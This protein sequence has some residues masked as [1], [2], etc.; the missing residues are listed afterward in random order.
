MTH[1]NKGMEW[2]LHL[3]GLWIPQQA[4]DLHCTIW[5]VF[6]PVSC[7]HAN[8]IYMLN[9]ACSLKAT[10][11]DESSNEDF[12]HSINWAG[13]SYTQ[14]HMSCYSTVSSVLPESLFVLTEMMGPTL[15]STR[16]FSDLW[17]RTVLKASIFIVQ[18]RDS[19][20]K[21]YIRHTVYGL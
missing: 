7:R 6:V 11:E 12:P 2:D 5:P 18:M 1:F 17:K 3:S 16:N 10:H 9:R 20:E 21:S 4:N 15:Y 13:D 19:C 8:L 14:I